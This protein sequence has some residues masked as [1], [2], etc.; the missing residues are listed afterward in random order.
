MRQGDGFPTA[1]QI[2]TMYPMIN[3]Y[4]ESRAYNSPEM[5]KVDNADDIAAL[6]SIYPAANYATTTG[7][8]RG[9]LV[10]KDGTTQLTGSTSSRDGRA[11][12]ST[13]R[14][15]GSRATRHRANWVPMAASS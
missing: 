8:L 15:P 13:A 2:E 5:A 9:V 14:S 7:T 11:S 3:P 1:A 4:P 12:R 10:A 6:S